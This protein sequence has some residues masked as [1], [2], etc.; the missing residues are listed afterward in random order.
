MYKPQLR[1]KVKKPL[2]DEKGKVY[3]K[4]GYVIDSKMGFISG[5]SVGNINYSF[6]D[7]EYFECMDID[8]VFLLAEGP[9]EAIN[10]RAKKRTLI[11]H[12]NVGID[13]T[14]VWIEGAD[15]P[16]KALPKLEGFGCVGG[17]INTNTGVTFTK[18][19][20]QAIVDEMPD[21]AVLKA[22]GCNHPRDESEIKADFKRENRYVYIGD[23]TYKLV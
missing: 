11:W 4:K 9:E 22:A 2:V 3:H 1:F 8:T 21:G 19:D 7:D 13:N 6:S 12:D 23:N 10:A 15:I 5:V 16:K 17:V 14:L 20:L 18:A